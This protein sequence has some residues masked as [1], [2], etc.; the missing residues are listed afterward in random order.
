MKS[1]IIPY[2]CIGALGLMLV[3]SGC[4][5][6]GVVTNTQK[7]KG[8]NVRDNYGLNAYPYCNTNSLVMLAFSGGGTRAA[9][10]AY[11]VMQELRDTE[12]K[13]GG[14]SMRALDG[15]NAIS[16]V[17][18][19][20]F[21]SMY[22]GLYGDRIFE[23][24]EEEFLR[25]DIEGSLIRRMYLNPLRW[26]S[27]TGRTDPAVKYYQEHLFHHATFADLKKEDSPLILVNSSDLGRGV[28]FTFIQEYFDLLNSDID[29]FPVARAVTASSAVPVL[30]DPVVVENYSREKTKAKP[31]WIERFESMA[32][33]GNSAELNMVAQGVSSYF[34]KSD[35]GYVHFVDGGITD[36]LGLLAIHDIGQMAGG[37]GA[38]YKDSGFPM[39]KRL[40]LISVNAS[41]TRVSKIDETNKEPSIK[42]TMSSV[43]SIQMHRYN[44][45]TISLM[46]N[47]LNTWAEQMSTP[48]QKVEAYFI[49]IKFDDVQDEKER[50]FLNAIPTSFSLTDQQVDALI[51]NGRELLRNNAS[52]KQLISTVESEHDSAVHQQQLH[53]S[54]TDVPGRPGE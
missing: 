33:L 9:A 24:F 36:N 54:R 31:E 11:G 3:I 26:F 38:F 20:S 12:L 2:L 19:G 14:Q 41:A 49:Q 35:N 46:Q 32:T 47:T 17:S 37:M 34:N 22:Y 27:R 48:E 44:V 21:V 25:K 28:R 13:G 8:A 51:K 18:G 50:E 30:F 42:S 16:S 5:S 53:E 52:F 23:D 10:F 6:Y 45:S 4:A 39:P 7:L 29:S 15:V 40:V 43:M 1:R